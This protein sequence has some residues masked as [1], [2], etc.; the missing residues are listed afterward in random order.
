MDGTELAIRFSFSTNLLR[1]CGPE[2]ATDAFQRYLNNK[3][4]PEEVRHL[5]KQ[6][7]GLY[8]YL[9]V[10]A[11]KAGKDFLDYEVVEAY[12]IGNALLD[13]CTD[14]EV[15]A[16]IDRLAQRGLPASHTASLKK[17]LPSGLV[18][19]HNF[20]VYY[21]GVGRITSSVETTLANM[22]NC[23]TGWGVVQE[24]LPDKLM[25]ETSPLELH[26]GMVVWGKPETK[27]AVY[28]PD[29]LNAVKE[30]DRVAL[31]WGYA[32]VVLSEEQRKNL[33]KYDQKLLAVLNKVKFFESKA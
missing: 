5:F 29:T 11:E 15:K 12:W 6:F 7:E 25:V 27:T 1:F 14:E 21:V 23:R 28:L 9:S 18:L 17:N 24:V 33:E 3:D 13:T 8:P 20:N 32:P 10:L 26:K 16:L 2:K 4:N 22:D 31:H 30:G 19:H